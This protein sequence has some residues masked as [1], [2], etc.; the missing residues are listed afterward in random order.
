MTNFLIFSFFLFWW[1]ITWDVFFLVSYDCGLPYHVSLVLASSN[2]KI[3]VELQRARTFHHRSDLESG[4]FIFSNR[5]GWVDVLCSISCLFVEIT[6]MWDWG[7]RKGGKHHSELRL[8]RDANVTRSLWLQ[9]LHLRPLDFL[10]QE[11]RIGIGAVGYVPD[12]EFLEHP[13]ALDLACLG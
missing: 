5:W 4:L 11:W 13:C 6:G 9:T 8:L 10:I 1:S 2:L 12:S 7:L 3:W